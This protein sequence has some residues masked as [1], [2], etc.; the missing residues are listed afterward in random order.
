[1]EHVEK[2]VAMIGAIVVGYFSIVSLRGEWKKTGLDDTVTK[3]LLGLLV[4]G[5]V[6]VILAGV[7]ILPTST[8]ANIHPGVK[9]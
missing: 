5:C 7:G 8:G 6:F 3:G 1:M 2:I 4:L 9:G